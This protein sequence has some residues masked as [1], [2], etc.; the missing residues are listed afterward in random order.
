MR[1]GT[2][3]LTTI[4]AATALAATLGSA[5]SRAATA[6]TW[7]VKPG[8]SFSGH[9]TFLVIFDPK[10]KGGFACSSSS[11]AGT[12][13]SGSGLAGSGL[14]SVASFSASTCQEPAA[15]SFTFSGLPYVLSASSYAA[16]TTKGKIAGIHAK[17]LGPGCVFVVDGTSATA[18]NG[19]AAF[20][21]SNATGKL[22]LT[23][24]GNLHFYQVSGCFGLF[25]SGDPLN[26]R[27]AFPLSP[28]QTITSP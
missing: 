7:T 4:A 19:S 13:K 22:M 10:T 25:K 24:G 16:G 8:G 18:D 11:L 2:K 20:S 14:G 26:P 3:V 1:A 9:S 12:L 21:Y 27:A 6:T 28:R 5:S 15:N 17:G 23:A